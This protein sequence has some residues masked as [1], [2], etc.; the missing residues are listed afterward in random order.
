MRSHSLT[1]P[2]MYLYYGGTYGGT[3]S[4]SKRIMC[5]NGLYITLK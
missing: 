2:N 5:A 4:M 1:E 3:T